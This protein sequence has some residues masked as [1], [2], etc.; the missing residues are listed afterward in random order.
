MYIG[1]ASGRPCREIICNCMILSANL[2]RCEAC[3]LNHEH[4]LAV[5][6]RWFGCGAALIVRFSFEMLLVLVFY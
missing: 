2:S 5:V 4:L 6:S 3:E 1:G